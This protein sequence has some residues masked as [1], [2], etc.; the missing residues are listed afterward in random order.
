MVTQ[1]SLQTLKIKLSCLPWPQLQHGAP[2]P[3]ALQ[4]H[5]TAPSLPLVQ[6]PSLTHSSNPQPLQF[7]SAG[8]EMHIPTHPCH[9]SVLPLDPK[10]HVPTSQVPS[11]CRVPVP[12]PLALHALPHTQSPVSCTQQHA[13]LSS[14]GSS[15]LCLPGSHCSFSTSTP[16]FSV[17]CAGSTRPL[18]QR[19][20]VW[21]VGLQ[22][23]PPWDVHQ[24]PLGSRL[25]RAWT[26][27]MNGHSPAPT[28]KVQV[29]LFPPPGLGIAL[30]VC[31]QGRHGQL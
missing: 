20:M 4:P 1:P 30:T 3:P 18:P 9:S 25:S 2:S 16:S 27:R 23:A 8:A 15:L 6:S 10:L 11:T 12:H 14:A 17:V 29:E 24:A 5:P 19:W 31:T 21:S 26:Y 13:E 22:M 28:S 7:S